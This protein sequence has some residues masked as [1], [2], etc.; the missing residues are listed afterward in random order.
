MSDFQDL[1]TTIE[2]A[3]VD[4]DRECDPLCGCGTTYEE[5]IVSVE[6]H[7]GPKLLMDPQTAYDTAKR[8]IIAADFATR[9]NL[10]RTTQGEATA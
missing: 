10:A 3:N 2:I 6:I 5:T 7:N 8:L 9:V 1:V 4:V